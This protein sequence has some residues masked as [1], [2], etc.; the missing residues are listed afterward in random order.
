MTSREQGSAFVS[1]MVGCSASVASSD[2]VARAISPG[3]VIL[4][5]LK[6]WNSEFTCHQIGKPIL[7]CPELLHSNL[8]NSHMGETC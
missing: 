5:C 3:A 6:A 8:A 1:T 4:M 7:T 2:F